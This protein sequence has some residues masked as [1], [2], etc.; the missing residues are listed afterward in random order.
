MLWCVVVSSC[1]R[2]AG[3]HLPLF[4]GVRAFMDRG[5]CVD[6]S[7]GHTDRSEMAYQFSEIGRSVS[8]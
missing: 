4:D 2:T 8:M 6:L 3:G 1:R 5:T 7:K